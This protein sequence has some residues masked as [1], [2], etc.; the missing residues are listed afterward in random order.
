MGI[1]GVGEGGAERGIERAARLGAER[2]VRLEHFSATE[3]ISDSTR[4]ALREANG[5]KEKGVR[6]DGET[7]GALRGTMWVRYR[8]ALVVPDFG[9]GLE[10]ET[11]SFSGRKNDVYVSRLCRGVCGRLQTCVDGLKEVG[12]DEVVS[13]VSGR[14]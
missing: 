4:R 13:D 3:N 10:E 11:G 2:D 7:D 5:R 9:G 8:R 12:L 1:E 14:T 6:N